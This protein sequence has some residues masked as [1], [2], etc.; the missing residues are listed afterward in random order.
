MRKYAKL[1]SSLL[2]ILALCCSLAF[3]AEAPCVMNA[4]TT[5]DT[6]TAFVKAPEAEISQVHIGNE[7]CQS[8]TQGELGAIRTV[9][10]VDNS[11]SIRQTY[12]EGIKD[13]LKE[14]VAARRDGDTFTIATFAKDI[15]YLVQDSND[16]LDIRNRID[17]FSFVDQETF[18][19][20]TLYDVLTDLEGSSAGIYT[21]VIVIADGV[22]NETLGYTESELHEKIQNALIPI[23]TIGC[24]ADNNEE[25]LKNMFSLSRLSNGKSYLADEIGFPGILQDILQDTDI[26]KIT[27]TPPD[28]LCDGTVKNVR[29]SF[30]EAYCGA[31]LAMPFKELAAEPET[32]P[33]TTAPPPETASAVPDEPEASLPIPSILIGALGICLVCGILAAVMLSRKRKAD[34]G[35]ESSDLPEWKPVQ[36]TKAAPAAAGETELLK[37]GHPRSGDETGIISGSRSVK[38]C[39]QDIKDPSRTFEY[40]IRDR[41]LIGRDAARCQIVID[42]NR[43]ISSVH[44]EVLAKGGGYV[45][46]DGGGTVIASKN[47]TFV[48]EKKAAPEQPLPSG[49]TLRLGEVSFKV[50]FR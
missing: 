46:R 12:R 8:Y 19:S 16:Y 14:L 2:C 4:Q 3:G 34:T 33:E 13:F 40:P 48:N 6:I 27:I 45:V 35:P 38:L 25:N 39:L 1:L 50:S 17:A 20:N 43:Y 41:V 49:S 10:I 30:G 28:A 22:D 23:Y 36:E 31:E 44:C 15:T 29:I 47:G 9:V 18:F 24:S 32:A 42:Y 21:R 37:P 26:I 5:G 7:E 11:L